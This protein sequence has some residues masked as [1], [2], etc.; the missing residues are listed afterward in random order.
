M[1][2]PGGLRHRDLIVTFRGMLKGPGERDMLTAALTFPTQFSIKVKWE[3]KRKR[4]V[5]RL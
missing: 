4:V 2:S 3:H 1:D 5:G